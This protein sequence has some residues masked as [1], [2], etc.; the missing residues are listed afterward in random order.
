MDTMILTEFPPDGYRGDYI[1]EIANDFKAVNNVSHIT[2]FEKSEKL[3]SKI[4][5]FSINF[6][7]KEQ[8]AD[9]VFWTYLS[10]VLH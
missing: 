3:L 7:R 8:N 9:L 5:E 10:I 4:K 6:L 2:K 1:K